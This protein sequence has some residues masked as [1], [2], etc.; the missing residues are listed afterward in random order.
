VVALASSRSV[1]RVVVVG[2]KAYMINQVR[3]LHNGKKVTVHVVIEY[4]D[5]TMPIWTGHDEPF[6]R[7]LL[8]GFLV[9]NGKVVPGTQVFGLSEHS[10]TLNVREMAIQQKYL[11]LDD[12]MDA[13]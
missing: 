4:P 13:F 8:W 1:S 11:F 3:A 6:L 12:P 9:I 7:S 10:L 2:N 5:A